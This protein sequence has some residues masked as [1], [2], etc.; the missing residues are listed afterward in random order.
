MS[1]N[2]Y[3]SLNQHSIESMIKEKLGTPEK[4]DEYLWGISKYVVGSYNFETLRCICFDRKCK[5]CHETNFLHVDKDYRIRP[6]NLRGYRINDNSLNTTDK[7]VKAYNFLKNQ[8]DVPKEYQA[9]W[10]RKI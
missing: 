2:K 6:C 1:T 8:V 7:L 10:K 5:V 4:V 3:T 9:I